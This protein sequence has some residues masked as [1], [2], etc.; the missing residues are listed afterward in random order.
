MRVYSIAASLLAAL[1][2]TGS[3][4]A[5]TAVSTQKVK[6]VL[7]SLPL[8]PT[9]GVNVVTRA[10]LW[11]KY[12]PNIEIERIETTSGMP[13]VNNILAGKVDIAYMGDTPTLILGSRRD[14]GESRF[15]A[16]T[17]ADEGGSSAAF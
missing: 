11:K 13:M 10:E 3:A 17:E 4:L 6:V 9:W 15:I 14:V 5:Q 12:L 16:I 8:A 7:G 1:A 2:L